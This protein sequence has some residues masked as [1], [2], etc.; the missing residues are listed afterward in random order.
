MKVQQIY[1]ILNDTIN[2]E[3]I[4]KSDIV[5][6]DLSNIVDVG[7]ELDASGVFGNNFDNFTR[8]I[9]DKIGKT[10][11]V[12]RTYKGFAPNILKDGWEFG[13]ALEKVRCD[14]PDA[15]ENKTWTLADLANGST[16][17]PFVITK[18]TVKAKYYN[19]KTTFEI[20]I[21]ISEETVKEAFLSKENLNRFFS[22]IENR[23]RFKKELCSDA[24]AM[25]TINN[26]IAN[27][28]N[29]SSNVVNLLSDYN[30]AT[31]NSLKAVNALNDV[32]F[33]VYVA[34]TISLYKQYLA[35]ASVLYNDDEYVTFTP[36]SDLKIV[37]LADLEKALET[38]LY[39]T[40]YNVDFVKIDGFATIPYWQGSGKNNTFDSH[41]TINITA[42]DTNGDSFSV[43]QSG[44]VATM[45]DVN[46]CM[47]A[48]QNDRVTSI[49]NPKGEY[50]NYF[51]K[52]DCQYLNDLA[53]NCVVFV[54]NDTITAG[55]SVTASAKSKATT[56]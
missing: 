26:L 51:Y 45:F 9:I 49:Y 44:V 40:S 42:V 46:A 29:N 41:S 47:I 19:S 11:F 4:G 3:Q 33:L 48:N 7:K 39:R 20:P 31:G 18:P 16:V 34:K 43:D 50:W 52:Y 27:K 28:I 56:K 8:T 12:D 55:G 21:T 25:R 54:I 38:V 13:S 6:E 2:S 32:D 15:D 23:V 22:M 17:D 10:I 36:E 14:L 30:T 53:E 35:T 1:K 5:A 37:M 24:M